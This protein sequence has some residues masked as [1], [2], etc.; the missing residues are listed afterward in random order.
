GGWLRS[1]ERSYEIEDAPGPSLLGTGERSRN[2]NRPAD[3]RAAP[4]QN[5]AI[6]KQS[7]R[8]WIPC[9]GLATSAVATPKQ[10]PYRRQP[11]VA[12]PK[13]RYTELVPAGVDSLPGVGYLN[14]SARTRKTTASTNRQSMAIV[15]ANRIQDDFSS[16]P[17]P[18]LR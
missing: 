17:S 11:R 2:G 8:G 10:E 12:N 18:P 15:M 5:R 7:R 13:S 6:L 3:N 1:Q 16:M 4:I 14:S 9:R